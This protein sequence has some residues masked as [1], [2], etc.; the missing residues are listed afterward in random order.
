MKRYLK[1]VLKYVQLK[2]D[3]GLG[4]NF[5]IFLTFFNSFRPSLD[6]MLQPGGANFSDQVR[7]TEHN[8]TDFF[9]S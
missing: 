9:S 8:E 4:C 2:V 3:L 7:L 1:Y 5:V 6:A